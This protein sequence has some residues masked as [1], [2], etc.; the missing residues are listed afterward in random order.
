[1]QHTLQ[2]NRGTHPG[3]CRSPAAAG[4]SASATTVQQAAAAPVTQTAPRRTPLSSMSLRPVPG[5]QPTPLFGAALRGSPEPLGATYDK[6]LVRALRGRRMGWRATGRASGACPAALRGERFAA[7]RQRRLGWRGQC[8]A[9]PVRA[10]RAA[11][12][13]RSSPRAPPQ[14]PPA[15]RLNC[16]PRHKQRGAPFTPQSA[17][18]RHAAR[19]PAR[20]PRRPP[21]DPPPPPAAPPT[22]PTPIPGC[23]QLCT[24]LLRGAAR[25]P[26][27]LHGAG[28]GRWARHVRG[29]A[30]PRRKPHG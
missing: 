19:P 12:R 24:F 8:H 10:S 20:A 25:V 27:A 2:L 17:G 7:S 22:P 15:A 23:L 1:V 26:G 29:P 9:L 14:P 28:P 3:P 4:A 18:P 11:R 30:R 6:E 21:A 16:L 13:T 5:A